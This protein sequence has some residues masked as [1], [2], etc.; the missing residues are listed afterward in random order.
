MNYYNENDPHAA[1]WIRNLIAAKLIPNGIVDDRSIEDVQPSDLDGFVQHHFFCGIAGWSLALE[2]AGWSPDEPVFT[3]SPPCQPFSAA[4][5]GEGISDK[6]HLW[7]AWFRLI[8]EYRPHTIFAENVATAIG[9]GWLD[10]VSAD[11][12]KEDYSVGA[13]VYGAH[14]VGAPH[15]RQRLYWV[16]SDARCERSEGLR[17]AASLGEVRQGRANWS[18]DLREVI[19]SPYE[20]RRSFSQPLVRKGIDGIPS[21]VVRLRSYGNAI[22]PQAAAAFIRAYMQCRT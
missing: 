7:P 3:G 4:G 14:S 21:R 17:K 9:Y 5:S 8:R 13:I 16:A 15:I 6:R 10:V 22:V 11:L 12:E 1:Q 2:I 18:M 19:D 20:S